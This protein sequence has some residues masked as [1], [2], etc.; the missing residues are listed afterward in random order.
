MRLAVCGDSLFSSK[1]LA[2]RLDP[3]L[4]AYLAEADG[5]FTNAEFCTPRHETPPAP[6]RG[7][8]TAVRA[9][10]LDELA[11]LHFQLISLC[12]NHSGDYG[13]EGMM[14]TLVA[15][16]DRQLIPCGLGRT[17]SEARLPHFL[18]TPAGRIGVV[19]AASTRS[20]VFAAS[21]A[22]AGVTARP[23]VNPLRWNRAYVL[24]EKEFEELRRIDMLL[25]TRASVDE[26]NRIETFTPSGEEA[27]KFGSLCEEN[28]NIERGERAY[29]RTWAD[30]RDVREILKSIRDASRR[31]DLT[32]FSLHTH[33]GTEANWYAPE[34]PEFIESVCRQAIEAGADAVVG[35]GAHFMRGVEIYRGKPIFYNLGSLLM[36]FE[37]GESLISPEMYLCYG[38]EPDSRPSDL[39]GN[40]AQDAEGRRIGFASERRFS[41]NAMVLLDKTEEGLTWKM[42]PLD[43][44]LDGDRPLHRGLPTIADSV[45]GRRLAERLQTVSAKYGT[46]LF[47][48]E[49]EGVIRAAAEV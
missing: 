14:D 10:R 15:A 25:G 18:D 37:A 31:S 45:T 30:E 40:R 21:D 34:P 38:Y 22:G 4:V 26:G 3:R 47:Y 17:L 11:A 41:E 7:Y 33:E 20:E 44:H 5:A 35:H 1:N 43:L 32:I 8:M 42:V 9:D 2:K 19:A 29:V 28:L 36:E 48:D 13:W 49:T 16:E 12:N 27:F 39:H 23:G 24:P 6:G 46:R